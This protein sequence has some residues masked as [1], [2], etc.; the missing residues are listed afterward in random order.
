MKAQ[1]GKKATAIDN[2]HKRCFC[3]TAQHRGSVGC[4]G[5]RNEQYARE[6]EAN[7]DDS[8]RGQRFVQAKMRVYRNQHESKAYERIGEAYI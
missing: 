5:L 4:L 1:A 8:K 3:G 6:D 2:T 7:A